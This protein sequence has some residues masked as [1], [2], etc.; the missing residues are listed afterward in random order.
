MIR[1]SR[2]LEKLLLFVAMLGA[3]PFTGCGRAVAPTV[4]ANK[5]TSSTH[6]SHPLRTDQ[7]SSLPLDYDPQ[8]VIW[9]PNGSS[10]ESDVESENGLEPLGTA[11][12]YL[13]C[14]VTSGEDAAVVAGRMALD[15]RVSWASPDYY[16]ETA[17]SRGHSW[18]FDEGWMNS[19]GYED[20]SAVMRLGLS[21]AHGVSMGNGV[22]VAVLDTGVNPDH[23]LLAGHVIPGYDF[24][25]DDT[26]TRETPDGID[27]DGDGLIDEAIG[28]GTHVAGLV[29]LVAP[30]ARILPVRVLDEDGRGDAYT[31]ARGID[32]AVSHGARVLNLSLGMLVEDQLVETA[33]DQAIASGAVVVASAGNWGAEEPAEYPANFDGATA[34]AATDPTDAPA[35]FTSFGDFVSVCAPGEGI[36]SAYWNGNTA[37]WSGTSMAAPFVSGG[38]ALLLSVHPDWGRAEVIARLLQTATPLASSILV[39][40][41]NYGAGRL[42]LGAALAPDAPIGGAKRVS[43]G[44]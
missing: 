28:H 38:A 33:V 2:H 41:A 23:P 22:I 10:G 20:Q 13:V 3:I 6:V 40:P 14:R 27:H 34:V 43:V 21:Q 31:I 24:V 25:D 42:N 15:T 19:T 39:D 9:L 17:E 37:I 1:L 26:D 32:Y 4:P 29:A 18:A 16:G 44:N 35:N 30:R 8:K 5:A 36:R 11:S 7:T 12:G